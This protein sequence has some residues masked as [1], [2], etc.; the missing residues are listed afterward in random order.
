MTSRKIKRFA[1]MLDGLEVR[2]R[3][4][5]PVRVQWYKP[6]RR[7][8]L[9][10]LRYSV[11]PGKTMILK[12]MVTAPEPDDHCPI[13]VALFQHDG[14]FMFDASFS[15]DDAEVAIDWLRR[16]FAEKSVVEVAEKHGQW[17]GS[18]CGRPKGHLP[19]IKLDPAFTRSW[20]GTYDTT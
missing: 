5:P 15:V 9:P 8:T 7:N 19:G 16:L 12:V 4:T 18:Y 13:S 2:W 6:P 10:L 17:A 20:L 3:K 1:G 11:N 14:R